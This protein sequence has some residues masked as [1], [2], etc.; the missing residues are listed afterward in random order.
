MRSKRDACLPIL[1]MILR[2]LRA[3]LLLA[4]GTL[5]VFMGC[6]DLPESVD[7][8]DANV[9][10]TVTTESTESTAPQPGEVRSVEFYA[11][12]PADSKFVEV[13]AAES[14]IDFHHEWNPPREFVDRINSYAVGVGVAIG[15]V[16]GDDLPDVYFACQSKG[17]RL[18]KNLGNWKFTDITDS[19]GMKLDGF[20]GTGATMVD[21]DNDGDLDLYLCAFC[22]A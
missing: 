15:D 14:G 8:P 4:W 20:W 6:S 7:S 3:T 13:L 1:R 17:G 18:Y 5:V 2:P 11:A 19:T 22:A 16:D 21:I 12:S 10:E 9:T